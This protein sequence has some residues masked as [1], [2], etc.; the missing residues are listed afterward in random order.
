MKRKLAK[1][2]FDAY[3]KEAG[4]KTW[5]GRDIPPF[6]DVGDKVQ[7]NWDAAAAAIVEELIK[8]LLKRR[9]DEEAIVRFIAPDWRSA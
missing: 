6:S 4:G 1:I 2:A 3:N 5:D 9:M 8:D 7:A